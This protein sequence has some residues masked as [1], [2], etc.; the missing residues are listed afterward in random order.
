[1]DDIFDIGDVLY[2]KFLLDIYRHCDKLD[3]SISIEEKE[4]M[5]FEMVDFVG[6]VI[7]SLERKEPLLKI[8]NQN[9][10]KMKK[11]SRI[12]KENVDKDEF[13][14]S[15]LSYY[16]SRKKISKTDLDSYL[17]IAAMAVIS[18]CKKTDMK[19]IEAKITSAKPFIF[20]VASLLSPA[21]ALHDKLF[22]KVPQLDDEEVA[23][24]TFDTSFARYID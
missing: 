7:A 21:V 22:K 18:K 24:Q 6:K 5:A 9:S 10:R 16:I 1:M 8:D 19:N 15:V 2:Q 4:K 13:A 11:L 20:R 23:S 12:I 14:K 3:L 17:T